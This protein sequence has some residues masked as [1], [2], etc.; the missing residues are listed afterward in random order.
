MNALELRIPPPLVLLVTGLL[1]WLVSWAFPW[2]AFAMPPRLIVAGVFALVGLTVGVLGALSFRRA[3]TTVNPM[4]PQTASSLVTSGIYRLT[5]NPM[6]LGLLMVLL[7]WAA[8]LS[9]ALTLIPIAAFILYITRFQI[10]P[11]ERALASIFGSEF[12]AYTSR[13]RRWI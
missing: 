9:N 7:G 11:E 1:M 4:K 8:F 6:Y 2:F 5:R 3:C 12:I 13:V 10:E